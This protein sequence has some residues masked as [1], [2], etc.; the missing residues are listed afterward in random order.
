MSKRNRS[1]SRARRRQAQLQQARP[2]LDQPTRP[3]LSLGWFVA[4]IVFAVAVTAG[5]TAYLFSGDSDRADGASASAGYSGTAGASG[6]SG[7]RTYMEPRPALGTL[8]MVSTS[9]GQVR[10]PLTNLAGGEAQFIDYTPEQGDPIRLFAIL[11]NGSYRAAL[12]A[13][14]DCFYAKQGYFQRGNEMV[15][16]KCGNS[17]PPVMIDKR[18]GGC[19]PVA[20]PRKV[21]G[22]ELVIAAADI[23]KAQ[24]SL[25]APAPPG[26]AGGRSGGLPLSDL[27]RMEGTGSSSTRTR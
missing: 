6:Y 5:V 17:Y 9:D 15:C 24:A 18:P 3:R 13:C 4:G 22:D 14:Q 7:S 2:Q 27:L 20:L 10:I 8:P 23:E 26:A 21:E 19:H 1:R 12:D 25:L 16:R 11:D